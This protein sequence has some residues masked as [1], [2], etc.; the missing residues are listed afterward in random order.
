MAPRFSVLLPT[1]NRLD[2]LKDAIE[3][4]RLQKFCDWE[5]I[6]SDNFSDEDVMGYVN[7]LKDPRVKALRTDAPLSVTDNWNNALNAATG[8]YVVM[9]GD[10]DGLTPNYF[11]RMVEVIEEL[12]EPDLVYHGGYHFAFPG[13]M[14]NA[15]E[16]YLADVTQ[17][18]PVLFEH[19][20]PA[21]LSKER[22]ERAAAGSL[23]LYAEFGYNAQFFLFSAHLI[24]KL[25]MFG[26]VYQGPFPD[27]Y[28]ANMTFLIADH[29]VVVPEP[30]AIIGI[31]PKSFG[32]FHFNGRG[33][34]DGMIFLNVE[35]DLDRA[36]REVVQAIL[37]GSSLNTAWFVTVALIVE[38]LQ[39][40]DLLVDF[41]RY[42]RIQIA[43]VGRQSE[44]SG[45]ENIWPLLTWPE[46]MFALSIR[47]LKKLPPR[48]SAKANR[49]VD[50]FLR[51]YA[52]PSPDAPV[53]V[54]G[55]YKSRREIYDSLIHEK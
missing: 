1:K 35:G 21:K 47:G 15:P 10:D 12:G 2:L 29:I 44:P 16:G 5:I 36:P 18:Y 49:S 19:S 52:R 55:K 48:V 45:I 34:T 43:I 37:P 11:A 38:K 28:F 41:A 42:R 31:S 32:A 20:S 24:K 39:R 26:P 23:R 27:Y 17:Y 46:R 50:R 51:Q 4:V 8:D 25:R 6:V 30:L 9:L 14:P 40:K 13:V 53:P 33:E 54:K 22:A 7:D 3:T